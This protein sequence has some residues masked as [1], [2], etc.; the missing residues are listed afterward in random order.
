MSIKE[1]IRNNNKQEFFFS[2]TLNIDFSLAI[3]YSTI[4][5]SQYSLATLEHDTYW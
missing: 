1:E 2:I 4:I 3:G 5:P